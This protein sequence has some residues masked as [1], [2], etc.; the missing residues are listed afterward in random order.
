[1]KIIDK[2]I[3][4]SLIAMILL[5]L[6]LSWRIWNNSD[7]KQLTKK[8]EQT[9]SKASLLKQPADI[10]V[11]INLIY[12]RLDGV[13][14]YSNKESLL[15]G[16][17]RQVISEAANGE[18]GNGKKL[19]SNA[20]A[21][22]FEMN[23]SDELSLC[24][25]LEINKKDIP[26]E[27][28]G[29]VTFKR[30]VLSLEDGQLYFLDKQNQL[31]FKMTVKMDS[32]KLKKILGDSS[33]RFLEIASTE[34]STGLYYDFLD[35]IKLPKYSYI[36]ATQSYSVFSTAFFQSTND[37]SSN[38]EDLT[39]SDIKLTNSAG[40][41]MN[42]SFET[43][44]VSFE[45][46]LV[47]ERGEKSQESRSPTFFEDSFS[48]LKKVGNS[49]SNLRYYEGNEKKITYRNYV[50]GYPVFSPYSRGQV[51]FN[52]EDQKISIHTNQ[53]TLQV[54]VPAE[55]RVVLRPTHEV[56]DELMSTGMTQADIQG[57]QIGYTWLGNKET[58]QVVDL[59]PEWY[60]KFDDQWR[61]LP[62]TKAAFANQKKEGN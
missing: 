6:F 29:S 48:Y 61:S 55:E 60:I 42:V 16:L 62:E 3:R 33:N 27:L 56:I 49:L 41:K 30:L 18:L 31:V 26:D 45:G 36:L 43:G 54:P 58:K 12:H 19:E 35:E 22:S 14:L 2:L 5:S 25:F 52:K 28:S 1:M 39:N 38:S 46:R 10:F 17:V 32:T 4:V 23:M 50:E 20:L 44:E 34:G 51:V 40:D 21:E 11:P 15:Q 57:I 8:Q 9:T 47:S 24:Y 53:E 13:H 7:N 37:L 59:S